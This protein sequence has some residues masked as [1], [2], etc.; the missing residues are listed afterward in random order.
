MEQASGEIFLDLIN[1][2]REPLLK[3]NLV[4]EEIVYIKS[5]SMEYESSIVTK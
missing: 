1:Q 4:N 3:I 2:Y 5:E